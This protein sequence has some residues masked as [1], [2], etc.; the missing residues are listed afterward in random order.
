VHQFVPKAL[1]GSTRVFRCCFFRIAIPLAKMSHLSQFVDH[2]HEAVQQTHFF[3]LVEAGR[4]N[5]GKPSQEILKNNLSLPSQNQPGRDAF[6]HLDIAQIEVRE[7]N[8]H[9]GS[10]PSII[11]RNKMSV[12]QLL[13]LVKSKDLGPFIELVASLRADPFHRSYERCAQFRLR[14]LPFPRAQQFRC[15]P[16][17]GITAEQF[18]GTLTGPHDPNLWKHRLYLSTHMRQQGIRTRHGITGAGKF[19]PDLRRGQREMP[20]IVA[21]LVGNQPDERL[22][23]S[24]Q[25]VSSVRNQ[26]VTISFQITPT[27]RQLTPLHPLSLGKPKRAPSVEVRLIENPRPEAV[28]AAHHQEDDRFGYQTGVQR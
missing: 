26:E 10:H 2:A 19:L 14:H 17:T 16:M 23:V 1:V 7:T 12:D 21:C 9:R 8:L 22:N 6:G 11:V 4:R 3:S 27:I 28:L 18:V 20:Y 15:T 24:A 13:V 25:I 5:T